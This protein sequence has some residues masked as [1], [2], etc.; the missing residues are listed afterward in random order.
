[1]PAEARTDALKPYIV[2]SRFED[3]SEH[4]R[5]WHADDVEHAIEQHKDAFP[6]EE[7]VHAQ[8]VPTANP[9][10][11]IILADPHVGTILDCLQAAIDN[12]EENIDLLIHHHDHSEEDDDVVILRESLKGYQA[13]YDHIRGQE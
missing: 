13:A 8:R 4:E 3:G 9:Y 11:P 1:M 10:K 7:F 6:E 2:R 12:C 5:Q